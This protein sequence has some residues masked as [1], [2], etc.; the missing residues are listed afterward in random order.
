[1]NI[2]AINKKANF[3][4]Q[5]LEKY[6]AGLV[7]S[8]QE[9]KSAKAKH[10]KL[11]GSYVTIFIN[12][13]NSPEAW[14]INCHISPYPQAGKILNY[15]P[16]RSRKLLLHKNELNTLIGRLQS[17]H[18]TFVPIKVYTKHNLIKLEFGVGKGKKKADKRQDIKKRDID[19]EIRQRL[20]SAY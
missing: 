10:L 6:E 17:E 5:I 20:K 4:Y 11:T 14:L 12:K 2:L 1:M 9:V 18:L 3:D 13:Q 19:R 15:E 7:L 8:G 16:T